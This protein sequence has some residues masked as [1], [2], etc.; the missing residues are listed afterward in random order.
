MEEKLYQIIANVMNVPADS[1][2]KDSSPKTVAAWESLKH[3]NLL[4]AVEE[5]FG[6][7]FTDEDIVEMEDARSILDKLSEKGAE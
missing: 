7:T 4:L 6:V 2:D 5:A 3:M 1:I